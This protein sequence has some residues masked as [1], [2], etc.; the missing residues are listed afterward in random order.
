MR[1][2][3]SDNGIPKFDYYIMN[4]TFE[5]DT[6]LTN[7][8]KDKGNVFTLPEKKQLELVFVDKDNFRI[9]EFY[10]YAITTTKKLGIIERI[11]ED[12]KTNPKYVF[13]TTESY[14]EDKK[15]TNKRILKEKYLWS[16]L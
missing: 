15:T 9:R 16:E 14:I 2:G 7:I 10:S 13:V 5:I 4:S 6:N 1:N 11:I 8:S 3:F 12:S